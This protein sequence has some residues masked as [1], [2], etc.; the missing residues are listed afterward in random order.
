MHEYDSVLKSLLQGPQSSLLELIA[1]AKISRWLNV[2]LPN[3][4][5]MRV[6]LLGR[7]S[8]SRRLI[9][10]EL[11]SF[12]DPL[13]PV[14]MAEYALLVYRVYGEFPEQYVIYVGDAKM[15]MPSKLVGAAFRFHYKLIDIRDF[16]EDLLLNS[17]YK[18]DHILAILAKHPDRAKSIR[19]ILAK[20][21]TLEEGERPS[22]LKLFVLSG[23]RKLGNEIRAEVKQMPILDDIMT[24]DFLGPL[25]RKERKE[26]RQEGELAILRRMIGKRFGALPATFD[27]RLTQLSLSELE[28]LSLRLFD[29]KSVE[30]LFGRRPRKFGP[31]NKI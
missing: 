13:M 26:G 18:G 25:I 9:G 30:D 23:L 1:D 6:D 5:Q 3:V 28:A 27:K 24:H 16:S 2:E 19:R 15:R 14:R 22:A 21:A 31:S 11:Q 7:I 10:F 8:R 4:T 17:S 12:N 29:A 20:I